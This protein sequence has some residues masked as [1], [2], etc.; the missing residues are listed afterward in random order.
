[1]AN[2]SSLLL[3]KLGIESIK[4]LVGPSLGG[5]KALAFSILHNTV[6][7][8]LILISSATQALT[9]CNCIKITSKRSNQKRPIME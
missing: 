4:V 7:K 1:M 3:E 2:A 6:V 8:N 9:V 5:M